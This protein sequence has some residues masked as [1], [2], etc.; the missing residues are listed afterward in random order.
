MTGAMTRWSRGKQTKGRIEPRLNA[1]RSDDPTHESRRGA[2]GWMIWAGRRLMNVLYI[3]GLLGLLVAG[4]AGLVVLVREVGPLAKEWFA[5]HHVTIEGLDH[6]TRRDVISRL[7]LKSGTPLYSVNPAWLA[8]RLKQHPWIKEASISLVPFHEIRV[9]V[10]ERSPSIVVR[11]A[12][13][14]LLADEEG[15]ILARMGAKDDAS[16][17][18]LSGVDVRGLLQ[19]TPEAR[20]AVKT[21]TALARLIADTVGGRADINVARLSNVVASVHGVTFQ[22]SASSMDQQW[23]R[24]LQM[25]PALREVAF[26]HGGRRGQEIDLRYLDRVIIRG[27]G[28]S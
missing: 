12:Q 4:C 26:D 1:R 9:S 11:T 17:P 7:A 27:K 3:T 13:E 5:I 8:E 6:V 15:Y 2:K 23:H 14:N 24:F 22:L 21:G 16:L 10:V 28:V 25:R 18:V 19:G 20:H